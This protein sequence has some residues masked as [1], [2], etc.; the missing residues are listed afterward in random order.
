MLLVSRMVSAPQ[1]SRSE[2]GA[3]W[4]QANS[5]TNAIPP[6]VNDVVATA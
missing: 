2:P 1:L 3:G 4:A 6:I 5:V